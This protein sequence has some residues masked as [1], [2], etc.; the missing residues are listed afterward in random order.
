[1]VT[2]FERMARTAQTENTGTRNPERTRTRILSAALKEFAA[3]GF[4]GARVDAIAR[5]A[6][7]NKRMLYHYFGDKEGLFKA[8]LRRK[9]AERN[10]WAEA[11]SG[12]P[13]ETLPFWFE[14]ACKDRDWVRL[15]EWE[16]LQGANKK[17]ID[18]KQRR[19]A[20]N[21]AL[22]RIRQRQARGQV[23]SEYD[24]RHL[25]LAMR[26]LTMF[27]AAF[28][29][30]TELIMGRP[31][32]DPKFQRERAEF[33]KQFARAFKPAVSQGKPQPTSLSVK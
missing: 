25:M 18:A 15:L 7:I 11:S 17:L 12:E 6:A 1:M 10:A 5:R 33:L 23:S 13:A 19:L 20:T 26:S 32:T 31:L 21:R 2:S 8:V 16:A 27:P 14:A 30:L 4:A 3:H 22:E 29:Q 24:P 28:P 9:I